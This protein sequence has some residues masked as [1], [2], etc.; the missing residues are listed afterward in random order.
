MVNAA[1]YAGSHAHNAAYFQEFGLSYSQLFLN[2]IPIAPAYVNSKQAYNAL[3]M[4]RRVNITYEEFKN[5]F[6]IYTYKL[7]T[8]PFAAYQNSRIKLELRFSSAVSIPIKVLMLYTHPDS[9][10]L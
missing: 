7:N 4:Y 6:A 1:S 2:D 8:T 3:S 9:I 5:G 10:P